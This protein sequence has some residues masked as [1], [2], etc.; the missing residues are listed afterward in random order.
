MGPAEFPQKSVVDPQLQVH[1]VKNLR[2]VD[3]SVMPIITNANTMGPVIMI[4]EKAADMI[5][6]KY[7]VRNHYQHH[8]RHHHSISYH[9]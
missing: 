6:D 1:N 9:Y 2:V 5:N 3:A 7:R 4:A 8:D